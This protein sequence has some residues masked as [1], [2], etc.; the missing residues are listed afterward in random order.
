MWER[1]HWKSG[2]EWKSVVLSKV[3]PTVI[4]R[5]NRHVKAGKAPDPR[6]GVTGHAYY[7]RFVI[8]V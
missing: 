3:P 6:L 2:D 7:W 8:C 5:W 1:R 4:A